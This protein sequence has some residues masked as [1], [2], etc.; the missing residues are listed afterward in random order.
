[1]T[2]GTGS[3]KSLCY[4]VPIVDAVVKTKRARTFPEDS[5]ALEAR[6]LRLLGELGWGSELADFGETFCSWRQGRP[7]IGSGL[8][9][10]I[11]PTPSDG[12][13]RR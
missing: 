7:R 10:P 6:P 2:T 3:G 1:M 4:F 11:K 8:P 13:P 5:G 9:N 12:G